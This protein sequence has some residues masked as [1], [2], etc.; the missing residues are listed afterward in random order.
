M[1]HRWKEESEDGI[2]QI[3]RWVDMR[4]IEESVADDL[5]FARVLCPS[6]RVWER[7]AY[8]ARCT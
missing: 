8:E 1:M 2:W 3:P 5:A 4:A 6:A 7:S